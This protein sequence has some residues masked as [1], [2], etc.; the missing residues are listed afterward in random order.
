MGVS[1]SC[2]LTSGE[3]RTERQLVIVYWSDVELDSDM[4]KEALGKMR[5]EALRIAPMFYR[6]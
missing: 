4:R 6:C 5:N 1:S 2:R 3:R